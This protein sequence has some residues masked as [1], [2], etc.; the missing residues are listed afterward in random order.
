[1]RIALFLVAVLTITGCV[2][3]NSL[4]PEKGE[5]ADKS[6]YL[7]DTKFRF[8]CLGKTKN[9]QDMTKIV[10]S[11]SELK[12]IEEA[13]GK[14]VTGPNYPVTLARI[15]MYPED[16]SYKAQ[17]IGNEGRFF[18]IPVNE[19]TNIVWETLNSI[20]QNLFNQGS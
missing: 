1:M 4:I 5:P 3:M 2:D 8:I 19:R 11:R 7:V 9:C 13:Y 15:I 17:P 12:P 10:S 20:E 18:S 14:K 16:G 6:F